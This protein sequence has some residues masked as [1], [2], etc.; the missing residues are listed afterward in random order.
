[1]NLF[2]QKLHDIA[3][4]E[5]FSIKWS[6]PEK[7]TTTAILHMGYEKYYLVDLGKKEYWFEYN[8]LVEE[9]Q[10]DTEIVDYLCYLRQSGQ[11]EV[12][13]LGKL[14]KEETYEQI[15]S[16]QPSFSEL[17]W[18]RDNTSSVSHAIDNLIEKIFENYLLKEK[19]EKI[20]F[21]SGDILNVYTQ[22]GTLVSKERLIIVGTDGLLLP[23]NRKVDTPIEEEIIKREELIQYI[24]DLVV[25]EGYSLVWQHVF[26]K[27]LRKISL[28]LKNSRPMIA[29][30]M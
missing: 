12:T 5:V 23:I 4:G 3:G 8:T 15:L 1:M 16:I 22:D 6:N 29:K 27:Q 7:V 26:Q 30:Q 20:K 19:I 14:H 2:E 9:L 28:S 11:A 13:Y 17:Y 24:F 18:L 10:S 21:A 25:H